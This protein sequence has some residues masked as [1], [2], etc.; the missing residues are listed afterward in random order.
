MAR[1]SP[2]RWLIL[3]AL[4]FTPGLVGAVQPVVAQELQPAVVEPTNVAY[5]FLLRAPNPAV[6]CIGQTLTVGVT[7]V[8]QLHVP[9]DENVP[10]PESTV[11]SVESVHVEAAVNAAVL[12]SSGTPTQPVGA[13]NNV[14]P[15]EGRFE[16]TGVA[17]GRTTIDFT[18]E[19]RN[20]LSRYPVHEPLNVQV[21]PCRLRVVTNARWFQRLIGGTVTVYA[22]VYE[23]EMVGDSSGVYTGSGNV[24][25]LLYAAIPGCAQTNTLHFGNVNLRGRLVDNDQIMVDLAYDPLPGSEVI[26]C[27]GL[28]S[29]GGDIFANAGSLRAVVPS[30]G[31]VVTLPQR[32]T[33]PA[34]VIPGRSFV[35]IS[36][37]GD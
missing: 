31:G 36:P 30:R 29:G 25:W 26:A 24:V 14:V 18:G 13:I 3:S 17:A 33:G 37:L 21:I 2:T 4:V 23:G 32:L 12:S 22:V 11:L 19:V 6:I 7:V 28:G 8:S 5:G 35:Y 1:R 16:F 34:G 20:F 9:D 10:A 27:L 15:F